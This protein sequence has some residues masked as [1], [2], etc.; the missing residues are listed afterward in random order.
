MN[1][2]GQ[3]RT[4][5]GAGLVFYRVAPCCGEQRSGFLLDVFSQWIRAIESTRRIKAVGSPSDAPP[6]YWSGYPPS[7]RQLHPTRQ[8]RA[9]LDSQ[10]IGLK[11]SA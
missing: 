8:V 10:E 1:Q 3:A 11:G 9:F 2:F 4:F 7:A 6:E 5:E